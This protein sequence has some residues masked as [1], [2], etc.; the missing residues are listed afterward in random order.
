MC[1]MSGECGG[2]CT[3]RWEQC[4]RVRA[5]R[6]EWRV[7]GPVCSAMGAVLQGSGPVCSGWTCPEAMAEFEKSQHKDKK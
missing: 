3:V 2:L 5:V 7:W 4:Y 1:E 6:D